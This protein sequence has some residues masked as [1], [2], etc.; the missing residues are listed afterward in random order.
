MAAL[1]TIGNLNVIELLAA[2]F[3]V[4]AVGAASHAALIKLLKNDSAT[5]SS[6]PLPGTLMLTSE[7]CAQ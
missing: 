4:T 6:Q 7:L 1:P 3:L 2:R 5:E